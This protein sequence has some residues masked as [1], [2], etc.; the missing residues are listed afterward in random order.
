[1]KIQD[2]LYFQRKQLCVATMRLG[3]EIEKIAKPILMPIADWLAPRA[4]S[5]LFRYKVY[6]IFIAFLIAIS[7]L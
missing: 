4:E 3:F 1:M 2:T 7:F 5:K 6:A